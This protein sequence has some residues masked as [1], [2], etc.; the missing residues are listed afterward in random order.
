M[1]SILII[2]LVLLLLVAGG[3]YY[4]GKSSGDGAAPGLQ[5]GRLAACPSAPNCVSSEDGTPEGQRVEPFPAEA[6]ARI[7]SIIGELGGRVM[8]EESD[9]IAAEFT[10]SLF[11]FV[12]DVEFRR[13]TDGIHLR[14]ASRVGYSDLGANRKRVAALREQL[15]AGE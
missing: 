9:Y 6:W 12:D 4:L 5:G 14:S 10:S 1:K 8:R 7:P 2:L 3:L 13:A 11:R 15:S